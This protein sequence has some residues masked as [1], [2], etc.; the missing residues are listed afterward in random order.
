MDGTEPDLIMDILETELNFIDARHSH[1]QQMVGFLGVSGLVFGGIGAAL[2]VVFPSG[3]DAAGL[4]V[5]S[6]AA[7]SL[8]Y[9]LVIFGVFSEPVRRKLRTYAERET[10]T[11]KMVIEAIMSIQSGDNPRIVEHKLSV[12]LQ[13]KFRPSGDRPVEAIPKPHVT[14]P[15]VDEAFV[16]E[17]AQ[18]GVEQEAR[19]VRAVRAAVE[20][21]DAEPEEKAR[22]EQLLVQVSDKELP[23]MMMLAQLSHPL[24]TEV[25][26]AL[27]KTPPSL[28]Q[29]VEETR[30]L[31]FEHLAQ[32]TDREIQVLLREVD[33]RDLVIALKGASQE[34]R[35]KL[36]GNMSERVRTFLQEE[37]AFLRTLGPGEVFAVHAR[38]VG[39]VLQLV[40]RGQITLPA[41]QES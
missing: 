12:F 14:P 41:D 7:L 10:L 16:A 25:V 39:Q 32:L 6:A 4:A 20:H 8:C 30:T 18:Y 19:V 23:T 26:Q 24:H 29:Q 22:A 17:V 2:A 3:P 33:Q 9:G 27:A 5:A 37:M 35:D 1:A 21:S 28:V 34:M 31:T 15:T 40:Q 38:I 36:L 11:K 13:P